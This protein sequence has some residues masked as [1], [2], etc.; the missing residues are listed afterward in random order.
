MKLSVVI[1]AALFLTA[2][3]LVT[4]R[5]HARY[6]WESPRR[7]MQRTWEGKEVQPCKGPGSWCGGEE[8]PTECCEVCTFGWCT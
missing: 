2:C 4:A 6:L 7:K 3:Q 8:V 5:N 1:I